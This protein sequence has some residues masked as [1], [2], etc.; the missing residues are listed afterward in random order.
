MKGDWGGRERGIETLCREGEGGRE[1]EVG[2]EG[3]SGKKRGRREG[4]EG[5]SVNIKISFI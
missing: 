3:E 2:K 1:T 5:E 4:G